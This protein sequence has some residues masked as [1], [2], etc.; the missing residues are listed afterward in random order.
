MYTHTH[1]KNQIQRYPRTAPKTKRVI[2]NEIKRTKRK[3]SKGG[4][5]TKGI[6]AGKNKY[7]VREGEEDSN[8]KMKIQNK[9]ILEY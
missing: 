8:G 5:R 7:R 6:D 4:F 1:K 2:L 3:D 9:E